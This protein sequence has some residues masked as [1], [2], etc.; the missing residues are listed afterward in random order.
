MK[1]LL[2]I[3]GTVSMMI[4]IIHPVLTLLSGILLPFVWP[5]VR[6]YGRQHH[7]Q[8]RIVSHIVVSCGCGWRAPCLED[9]R[10]TL[11]CERCGKRFLRYEV[12]PA[13]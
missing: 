1:L 2:W 3:G 7:Q 9:P 13:R 11:A 5:G 10:P 8:E 4:L 6:T 12:P